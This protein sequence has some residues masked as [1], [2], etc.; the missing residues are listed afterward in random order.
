MQWTDDVVFDN[1]NLSPKYFESEQAAQ[2]YVSAVQTYIQSLTDG[3]I[4]YQKNGLEVTSTVSDLRLTNIT[5]QSTPRQEDIEV[6]L[7][8]QY[9]VYPAKRLAVGLRD[10]SVGYE[11]YSD[12]AEIVSL[13]FYFDKPVVALMLS[14][15]RELNTDQ[16]NLIELKYFVSL[17]DDVWR[18][19]SPVQLDNKGI[20][21]VFSMNEN[22]EKASELP[23]V[24][25]INYPEIPKEV[26]EIK[27]RIQINKSKSINITPEI[28]NYK[29]IARV[30]Q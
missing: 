1:P 5:R 11:E 19:I 3:E 8:A 13:P 6:P 20:A 7:S 18:A 17:G 15:D 26:K 23:G 14:V 10:V 24:Y 16:S 2:Q 9:E 22:V 27:V 25:Y 12:K 30:K 29:L 28:Y 4:T 21:E